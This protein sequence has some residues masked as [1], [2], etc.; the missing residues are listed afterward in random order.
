VFICF[1][2][3]GGALFFLLLTQLPSRD[4]GCDLAHRQ[5]SRLLIPVSTFLP[6]AIDMSFLSLAA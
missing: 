2:L 6:S 1:S 4:S 5:S 3:L